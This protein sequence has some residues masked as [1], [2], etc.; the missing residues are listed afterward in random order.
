M[1][2]KGRPAV[3]KHRVVVCAQIGSGIGHSRLRSAVLLYR[4]I[5]HIARVWTVRILKSVLLL[6]GV[7]MPASSGKSRRLTLSVLVDMDGMLPFRKVLQ[8]Q[9]DVHASPALAP[10]ER[11]RTD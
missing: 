5:R 11:R 8:V 1:N 10:S 2:H 3:C 9:L 4:E 6:V 7:E